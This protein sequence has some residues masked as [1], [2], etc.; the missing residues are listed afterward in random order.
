MSGLLSR[1]NS[2]HCRDNLYL[3]VYSLIPSVSILDAE[4]LGMG[5][6]NEATCIPVSRHSVVRWSDK[7]A[8]EREGGHYDQTRLQ[9]AKGVAKDD[10]LAKFYINRETLHDSSNKGEVAIVG[11]D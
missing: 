3:Y 1:K 5:S 7:E 11:V 9:A 4:K 10:Q 2:A 8:L 6:G